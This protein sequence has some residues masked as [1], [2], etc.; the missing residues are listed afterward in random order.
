[1]FFTMLIPLVTWLSSTHWFFAGTLHAWACTS[2]QGRIGR[3]NKRTRKGL[4]SHSVTSPHTCTHL[5]NN[6]M[7]V[8]FC[9]KPFFCSSFLLQMLTQPRCW[10][11]AQNWIMILNCLKNSWTGNANRNRK[12]QFHTGST[13]F[14]CLFFL[15]MLF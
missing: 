3:G 15:M 7:M 12:I 8:W 6:V 11:G 9:L 13:C 4:I 1:M 14:L 5:S 2:Q 10:F